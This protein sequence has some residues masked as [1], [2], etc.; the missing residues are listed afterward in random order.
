MFEQSVISEG[1]ILTL[2][3]IGTAFGLL[4]L[5]MLIITAMGRTA[6]AAAEGRLRIGWFRTGSTSTVSDRD[7]ALAAAV[8]V[9]ALQRQEAATDEAS[10][11]DSYV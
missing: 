11:G 2:I 3:G 8:A 6:A 7:K 4:S 10:R 5:M 1:V 9:S